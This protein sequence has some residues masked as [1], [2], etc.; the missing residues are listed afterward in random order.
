VGRNGAIDNTVA[1]NA[2]QGVSPKS[3]AFLGKSPRTSTFENQP[4]RLGGHSLWAR[5]LGCGRRGAAGEPHRAL[6]Q[7]EAEERARLL[8]RISQ[9]EW[10]LAN[11]RTPFTS[12]WRCEGQ[13]Q[14]GAAAAEM[15]RVRADEAAD[16][17]FE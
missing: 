12:L 3:S 2:Q 10:L 1:E 16:G 14:V 7:L 5:G 15:R 6:C 9:K 17:I 4:K 11:I 8:T 13:T